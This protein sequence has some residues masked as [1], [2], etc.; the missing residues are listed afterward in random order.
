MKTVLKISLTCWWIVL[1]YGLFFTFVPVSADGVTGTTISIVIGSGLLAYAG[2][3]LYR[4]DKAGFESGWFLTQQHGLWLVFLLIAGCV[5][6]ILGVAWLVAPQRFELIFD[7][8]AMPIAAAFVVLFWISLIF[9]FTAW[10]LACFSETVGYARINDYKWLI[11]GFLLGLLWLGFASGFC[12][13]FLEVINDIF[14]RISTSARHDIA[15]VFALVVMA[16]GLYA[17]RYE[18]LKA[19]AA[20]K[21]DPEPT[22]INEG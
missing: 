21:A 3:R 17:G 13:L 6:L 8:S 2:F 12:L 11:Y 5:L 20:D 9:T 18:D 22:S 7:R 19:L 14:V 10:S 4:I 1:S 16:I 15:I